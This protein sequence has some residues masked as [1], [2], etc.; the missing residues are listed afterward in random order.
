MT[1]KDI[2]YVHQSK[3]IEEAQI[4][5]VSIDLNVL[6]YTSPFEIL[7]HRRH[8]YRIPCQ[9]LSIEEVKNYTSQY[10]PR[11]ILREKFLS[12]FVG[13]NRYSNYQ[14]FSKVGVRNHSPSQEAVTAV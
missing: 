12:I 9:I 8:S 4:Q 10:H 11:Q 2:A 6:A 7:K 14:R 1:K 5:L 3:H 13:E